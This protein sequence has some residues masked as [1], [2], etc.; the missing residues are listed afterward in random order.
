MTK[1]TPAIVELYDDVCRT[2]GEVSRKLKLT[3]GEDQYVYIGGMNAVESLNEAL[4]HV[5]GVLITGND[6]IKDLQKALAAKDAEIDALRA[7]IAAANAMVSQKSEQYIAERKACDAMRAEN[8]RM[9]EALEE[10]AEERTMHEGAF[11]D[12]ERKDLPLDKFIE[13]ARAA[14]TRPQDAEEKT[15]D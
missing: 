12:V 5:E 11:V 15:D 7:D 9:Q 8:A 14:L 4:E 13:C 1:I 2:A 6:P 3:C 10:I